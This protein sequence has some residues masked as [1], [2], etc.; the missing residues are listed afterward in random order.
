MPLSKIKTSSITADAAS[1]NLNIDAGTLFLD[2]ANNR[3]GVGT[4]SP[5]A[6]LQING[7]G[8]PNIRIEETSSG[9]NKRLELWVDSSSAIAYVGANQSAQSL[10]LQTVGTTRMII[11]SSGQISAGPVAPSRNFEVN[12]TQSGSATPVVLKLNAWNGTSSAYSEFV[13]YGISG[14]ALGLRVQG[15]STDQ[16]YIRGSDSFVGIGTTNPQRKLHVVSSQGVA[17]QLD[18]A[19]DNGGTGIMFAGSNTAKNWY[20]G[21]QYQV[22]DGFEITPTST[23]GGLNI[24]ATPVLCGTSDGHV[25]VNTMTDTNSPGFP[26]IRLTVA[27]EQHFTAQSSHVWF[28]DIVTSNPLGIG[29]GEVGNYGTDSDFLS[30]Y[31]RNSVRLYNGV[32]EKVR[33]DS[34]GLKFYNSAQLYPGT[35][36]IRNAN[37]TGVESVDVCIPT[38][39]YSFG[40][41]LTSGSGST[42]PTGMDGHI[43]GMTWNSATVYGCQIYVDTDPTNYAAVRT[44]SSTGTWMSWRSF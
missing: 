11:D 13:S 8:T 4:T 3:I 30:L 42:S 19:G 7:T 5:N 18:D 37:N 38:N 41:Y 31:G 34:E 16:V 22:N 1:T 36:G 43:L 15:S 9:G 14:G 6:K 24:A 17:V 25:Y 33:V 20:I 26:Y 35:I 23:N 39:P 27:G 40:S 21:S 28:G 2:A 29:E 32:N 44:R 12:V 10:A